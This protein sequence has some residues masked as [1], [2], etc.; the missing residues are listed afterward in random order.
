MAVL[1][2][3]ADKATVVID[4]LA[5][6]APK[7]KEMAGVLKA[8]DLNQTT[9]LIG[10]DGHQPAIYKSARNIRGVEILPTAEFNAY[11]VLK[12]KRLVLTKGAL[13]KLRAAKA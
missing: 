13:E 6:D 2:K 3:L 7:T 4:E 1:A 9:C 8:L 11:T 10:T 5:M 12:Q